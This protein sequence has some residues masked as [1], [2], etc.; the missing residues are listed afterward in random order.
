MSEVIIKPR[1][2]QGRFIIT[3][4]LVLIAIGVFWAWH[5]LN[6]LYQP[7][8]IKDK[9]PI[10]VVI[11]AQATAPQ[12]AAILDKEQLIRSQTAFLLFCRRN[13]LDSQLK[14]GHYRFS[15]SQSIPQ[16][17]ALI[18]QGHVVGISF[19]V[20]EGYTIKQIGDL[21]VKKNICTEEDWKAA[22]WETYDYDFLDGVPVDTKDPLEGFLFPDTYEIEEGTTA[23]QIVDQ[24]LGNFGS[25]WDKY[26]AQAHSQNMTVYDTVILA[27]IIEKEA[28]V[29]NERRLISGVIENRLQT[30]MLLQLCPTVLYCIGQP[31]KVNVSYQ[32]LEVDSPYNTYKY[33]GLPPG[34][35]SCPGDASIAAA[36]SPQQTPYLYYVA[37]GDGTHY[38]S[39]TYQEHLQ[40]Q[41][42]Y[43]K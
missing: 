3:V 29:D 7:V 25:H 20:P 28:M 9:R 26:A 14:A 8:D 10:D 39:R 2:R 31:E 4:L 36:V 11:P 23:H 22:L 1:K 27:S 19:T 24:M 43:S 42:R 35:I 41:R 33:P 6:A 40:A 34:P 15:R 32:D 12:I 18:A 37:K 38:F 17:A 21:L 16:I 30:G 5:S 13:E